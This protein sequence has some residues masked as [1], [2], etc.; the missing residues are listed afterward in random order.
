MLVI[1][2]TFQRTW[3]ILSKTQA[4]FQFTAH[5]LAPLE[6]VFGFVGL[7]NH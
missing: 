5:S 1:V 2:V 4:D 3:L 7:G 6:H